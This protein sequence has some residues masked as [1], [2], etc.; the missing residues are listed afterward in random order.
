MARQIRIYDTT[1]RDGTQG[2]G[3]SFSMEDKVRL[4][5]RLDALGVHYI[6]GGWPGSNPKDLRFFRADPRRPA[7]AR[8]SRRLRRDPAARRLGRRPTRT[9]R[10]S[11]RRGPRSPRSSASR[12]TSTSR[13]RSRRRCDENLAMIADSVAFLVQHVEEVVYDAEHFFDGFKRE[14]RVRARDPAGGR[15]RRARSCLVLCDTNGG[16]LPSEVAEIVREVRRH[17]GIPLGIHVHNDGECAVA[18]SL[19]AVAGGRGAR[20]GDD[21]R[22]RRAVRQREPRVDHP[23]PH[24]EAGPRVRSRSS[25]LRE[26]RDVSRFVSELANR[27]PWQRQPYVGDSAFAHKGGMHVSAVLKHPETYEHID[28]RAASGNHRRVLV[29]ELAGQVEHPLEGAR[30]RDRPRQG[31]P[32]DAPHPRHAEA[33]RG[34]GVPVRGRGG[35]VRAPDGAGPRESPRRTS[36]SRATG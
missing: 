18:N 25:H 16:S 4:A 3:V 12:G 21:Q 26:L 28:A 15:A 34:R 17:V 36:S 5:Q 8:A 27:T 35:V 24:A 13:T 23:E 2:E 20:P 7:E 10:P 11:S 14:P 31:H 32:G 6:E 33:P 19:A 30:V 29:S 9:S 1:L 22:L